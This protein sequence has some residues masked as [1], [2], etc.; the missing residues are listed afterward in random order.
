MPGEPLPLQSPAT[1]AHPGPPKANGVVSGAPVELLSRKY[2][3]AV[4][5]SKEPTAGT[6]R[7]SSGSHSS[8]HGRRVGDRVMGVSSGI[9]EARTV[10]A[11]LLA[12][13]ESG[14][15]PD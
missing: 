4:A 13:T 6:Q 12:H 11:P 9:G 10:L 7:S 3:V 1:G 15:K 14:R 5:G 2:Q 8:C